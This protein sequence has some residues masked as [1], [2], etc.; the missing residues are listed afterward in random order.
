MEQNLRSS[1]LVSNEKEDKLIRLIREL[2]SGEMLVRIADGKPVL[3]EESR[4]VVT[5]TE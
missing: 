1:E 2:G 4:E 3:I 5:F